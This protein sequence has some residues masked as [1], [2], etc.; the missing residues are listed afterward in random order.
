MIDSASN[1]SEN[2]IDSDTQ[3]SPITVQIPPLTVADDVSFTSPLADIINTVYKDAEEDIFQPYLPRTSSA[4]VAQAIRN[5][6]LA[7]AYLNKT[8]EPVGCIS[9][10]L[11]TADRGEFGMLALDAKHRG[12]GLGRQMIL[13]AEDECRRRGCTIMQLEL[14]VPTT[15]RHAGKERMAAWY[16]R[17]GYTFVKVGDF[18]AEYPELAKVLAG[19]T[20]Y[21]IFE[22][23][24]V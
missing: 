15:V 19:P 8:G 12:S 13:F 24:L 2:V 5:G 22:K 21:R 23:S 3:D 1:K 11:L 20:E 18:D 17:L 14:L 6:Q 4:E 16:L 10:K 9:I 7:V